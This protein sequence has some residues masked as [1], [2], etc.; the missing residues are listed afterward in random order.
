MLRCAPKGMKIYRKYPY[1]PTMDKGQRALTIDEIPLDWCFSDGV[2]LDFRHK[3]DGERITVDDVQ[4]ELQ[5]I[6][7]EI[8]PLDIVL[9]QLINESTI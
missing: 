7:Y 1:H 6:D 8:K 9:I 5:R 4:K 2:V 3:A